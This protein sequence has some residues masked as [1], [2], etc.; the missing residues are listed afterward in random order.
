MGKVPPA[1]KSAATVVAVLI[2]ALLLAGIFTV[3]YRNAK[4][5]EGYDQPRVHLNT[6]NTTRFEGADLGEVAAISG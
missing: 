3:P 1:L 4:P 2:A 5:P 6:K